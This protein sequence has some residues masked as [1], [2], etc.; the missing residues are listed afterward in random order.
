MCNILLVDEER[1]MPSIITAVAVVN[2]CGDTKRQCLPPSLL[3]PPIL[4]QSQ[5]IA[6]VPAPPTA[7]EHNT[8]TVV[9]ADCEATTMGPITPAH[10]GRGDKLQ[11]TH[12][13]RADIK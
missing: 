1:V 3:V 5:L 7:D 4:T 13:T 2:S 10:W 11:R 8:E 9:V 6:F 12:N